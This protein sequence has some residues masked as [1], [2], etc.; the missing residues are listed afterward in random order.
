MRIQFLTWA[1]ALAAAGAARAAE[2]PI[3]LAGDWRF[4]LDPSAE[5]HTL[6]EGGPS[7]PPLPPGE[8]IA[9][10][11]FKRDLPGTI[12]LPGI[13]QGQNYGNPISPSTPWV[14]S[15]GDAWWKLQ[16]AALRQ[17]F[18]QP[19]QVEVPFL[20]QP[21]RH[22]LGVAWY[23]RQIEIPAAWAA[24]RVVLLLE[25]PH[26]ETR[27]WVD[28]Q[29]FA[30][31]Q[32]LVAPHESDLGLLAPGS[33]RLTIRVDNRRLVV[34]PKNDGHAVDSH[35]LSDALGAAWNGITGRIEL[36]HRIAGHD[37]GLDR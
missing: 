31:D 25:H 9:A 7:A 27:V 20:S 4:A 16:P 10:S 23:Q 15:L 26:W 11:W 36:A 34:D 14:L 30:P 22:Y 18:S 24:R 21:P 2:E 32:S 13:L 19:G 6:A 37:A 3:S 17:K 28:D 8:G 5:E 12:R 33:H 29:P 1:L 35:S